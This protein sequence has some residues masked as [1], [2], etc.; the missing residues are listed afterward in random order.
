MYVNH[1]ELDVQVDR[2]VFQLLNVLINDVDQNLR[3]KFNISGFFFVKEIHL[4]YVLN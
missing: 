3:L 4:T 1:C 2:I